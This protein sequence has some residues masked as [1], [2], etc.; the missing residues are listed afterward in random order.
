MANKEV[1]AQFWQDKDGKT[2]ETWIAA[3]KRIATLCAARPERGIWFDLMN[4]PLDWTQMPSY[5]QQWPIWAQRLIDEIRRIDT[6]HPIVIEPGPGS[7]CGGFETF[8]ASKG[9]NLIYSLHQYQPQSYTHQGVED[10]RNT[11]L[12][13]AYLERQRG[14]PGKFNDASGGLWD[15]ARLETM[16]Q[17]VFDFVKRNPD[18]HIYVGEFSVIRWAPNGA[19]YLRDNIEIFEQ[20]GWDWTYHAFH[21][22]HGWSPE[23][24]ETY[25]TP[26]NAIKSPGVNSRG[27]VL[28]EFFK[29]NAP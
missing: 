7:L 5:P 13:K 4:E 8:P 24:D 12:A 11:D 28:L 25:S 2:L 23:Y 27:A 14:W 21:E 22:W 3:W 6:V 18:A 16:L 20:H 17:P 26:E 15:K 1:L 29:R 9:N 10:I 19:Q